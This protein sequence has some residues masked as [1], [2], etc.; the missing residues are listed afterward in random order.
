[1]ARRLSPGEGPVPPAPDT[2][3]LY[4]RLGYTTAF[5]AAVPLAG[6]RHAHAELSDMPILD[7]GLYVMLGND[8]VLL[9]ALDSG[10][11]ERAAHVLSWAVKAARAYAVKVVDPGG[12]RAWRERHAPI[13][14]D[15]VVPG[16]A[17]T[18]RRIVGAIAAAVDALGLP[19]PMHLHCNAL[20]VAGN[21]ATTLATIDALEGRR[22]HLA[23]LQFHCYGGEPGGQPRSQAPAVAD[24]L[25]RSPALSA[26][27]GQVMFGPATVMTADA[28]AAERLHDLTGRRWV[29]ADLELEGGCGILPFEYRERNA[30]HAAQFVAGLELMLLSSDPWRMVLSTDHP[31]GGSFLPYPRLIRLLMDRGFRDE[32]IRRLPGAA[33]EET[34][35]GEGL[36]REYTLSEIAVVTRAAPAR[37]LGLARKGHLGPGADADLAL[38]APEA[39]A[40]AMFASPRWVFK[41]GTAVV[42]PGRRLEEVDGRTLQVSPPHDRGVEKGI[43]DFLED[44]GTLAFEDYMVGEQEP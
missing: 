37:L 4:A 1:M 11:D 38:Y 23:H 27:V 28:G 21:V 17:L 33:L 43:R 10:E 26:D 39:D 40:E 19:H 25:K 31:N 20:G 41:A 15:D 14:L 29:D 30:V 24:A 12:F 8:D 9:R 44:E 2:G 3:R 6:A 34:A 32:Q 13:G 22:A 16:Y 36:E 35:L 5:D 42:A 18:P 7:K